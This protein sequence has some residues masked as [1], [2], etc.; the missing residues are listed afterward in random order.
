MTIGD[1]PLPGL[2]YAELANAHTW[3]GYWMKMAP[4]SHSPPHRHKGEEL[5]VIWEGEVQDSDGS[6][7]KAGSSLVYAPDSEHHLHSPSGCVML[8]IESAAAELLP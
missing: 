2:E 7:F 5:I 1:M 3:H 8:V 6:C 4:G